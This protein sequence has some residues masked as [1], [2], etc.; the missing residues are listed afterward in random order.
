MAG[1]RAP[2]V[3][4]RR[5]PKRCI[6]LTQAY[7]RHGDPVKSDELQ[8]IFQ[9]TVKR[10][11]GPNG[12]KQLLFVHQRAG[13]RTVV[14][15]E[16]RYVLTMLLSEKGVKF[17]VEVPTNEKYVFKGEG[18][19]PTRGRTDV[20]IDP[21]GRPDK[22]E[23]KAAAQANAGEFGGLRQ[24]LSKLLCEPADGVASF[25]V[26]ER[27]TRKR[28][29]NGYRRAYVEAMAEPRCR[30]GRPKSKWYLLSVLDRRHRVWL[31]QKWED[32]THIN[33]DDF[34]ESRFHSEPLTT[35]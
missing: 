25:H 31:W 15:P 16:V 8:G 7:R 2:S 34:V 18:K 33:P 32:I 26:I 9:E 29:M 3:A 20:V 28:L 27:S 1:P 4:R 35:D 23:L 21:E 14:E 13:R 5:T 30:T 12:Y 24:D 19:R 22:I 10:L 6:M 17:G 11:S